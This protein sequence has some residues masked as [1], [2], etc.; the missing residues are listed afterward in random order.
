MVAHNSGDSTTKARN[1]HS[2][3]L[4]QP[5]ATEPANGI[6]NVKSNLKLVQIFLIY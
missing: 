6:A 3:E 2:A 1:C 4:F 5:P